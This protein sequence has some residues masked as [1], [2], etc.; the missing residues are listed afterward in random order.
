MEDPPHPNDVI[1]LKDLQPGTFS[2][3]L[4][5][6]E[7]MPAHQQL[8]CEANNFVYWRRWGEEY[9]VLYRHMGNQN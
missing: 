4:S 9:S 3:F 5:T 7:G 6:V 8:S 2:R 1:K